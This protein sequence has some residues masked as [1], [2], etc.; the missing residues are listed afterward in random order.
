[1][2]QR[3]CLLDHTSAASRK[4]LVTQTVLKRIVSF[5]VLMF[6]CVQT[7]RFPLVYNYLTIST[8]IGKEDTTVFAGVSGLNSSRWYQ[9]GLYANC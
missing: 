5:M 8:T 9:S 6:C 7:C 3:C 2:S 4:L 1:M